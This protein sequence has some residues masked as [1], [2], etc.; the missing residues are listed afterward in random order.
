MKAYATL[1]F[2]GDELEPREISD[3]LGAAPTR[4]CRKGER[5]FA[6]PRAGELTGRTGI[7]LL[8]TDN[9]VSGSDLDRHVS[10]L[11]NLIFESEPSRAITLRHLIACRDLKAHVSCLSSPAPGTGISKRSRRRSMLGLT[12]CGR[13]NGRALPMRNGFTFL[14]A[15]SRVIGLSLT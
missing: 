15:S 14:R 2:T 3:V 1:R 4:A 13:R 10:Y 11:A 5:Y 12:R 8:S 7:W 9:V 6:G